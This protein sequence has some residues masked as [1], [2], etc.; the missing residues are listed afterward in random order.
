MVVGF[1]LG[2]IFS[3]G[4]GG[5]VMDF[6]DLGFVALGLVGF[7]GQWWFLMAVIVVVSFDMGWICSG[8][9]GGLWCGVGF[10][11]SFLDLSILCKGLGG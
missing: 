6:L 5:F 11:M 9:G 4:G 7:C 10:A 3:G 1:N 8:V 2:W